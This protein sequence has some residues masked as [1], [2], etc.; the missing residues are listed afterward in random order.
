MTPAS[1]QASE[2]AC[3]QAS[4]QAFAHGPG[5][6]VAGAVLAGILLASIV[7]AVTIGPVPLSPADVW[8]VIFHRL[9]LGP[10]PALSATRE[11]IVW[12]LRLP[13]V[14][15]AALVGA[16]LSVC[17]AIMQSVS[18]N[19]LADP[20]LLGLSSGAS[21]GAVLVVILGAGGGLVALSGGA[22]LGAMVAFAAVLLLA[23][24]GRRHLSPART[25]LAGV[26]IAYLGSALTS[27]ITIASADAQAIRSLLFWLL[28]TLSGAR[29]GDLRTVAA[30]LL[31]VL[32]VC[33]W[34]ARSLNAF[35]FGDDTAISLGVNVNRVRWSLLVA[36]ALVT[37]TLVAV[38]G[39]I[40]FVG[41]VLPHAVRFVAG[42]D[43]RRV[44]P[45]SALSGA[46]FLIWADT[47]A[48]TMLEPR[49]IP[50]GVITALCG[51]PAFAVLLWRQQE[52]S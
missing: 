47:L 20:Y 46:I 7:M 24:G 51:V 15:L 21:F 10:A 30:V 36:T 38:S 1:E 25:V 8:G 50:V 5:G 2:Q 45:L 26:A 34:S 16:G 40:G 9:G 35:T 3:E 32:A 19:P 42:A 27:L 22:F 43:H 39:A 6:I 28:G 12:D 23:S 4:E 37:A 31:P 48:R 14:L 17:G 13:R 52:F 18:R 11:A 49:E 44:L 33:L 41:L 29:W